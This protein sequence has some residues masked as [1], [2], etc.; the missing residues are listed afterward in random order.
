MRATERSRF[1]T[2]LSKEQ[3]DYFEYAAT[4]AGFKTMTDFV[5]SAAQQQADAIVEKHNT[6]LASQKDQELFFDA[7][8]NPQEPNDSLKIAASRFRNALSDK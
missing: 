4:L 5:L 2:R 6:I 7:L 3:K 8:I 1:D